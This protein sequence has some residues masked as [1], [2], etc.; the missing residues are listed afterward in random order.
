MKCRKGD[1]PIMPSGESETTFFE[2]LLKASRKLELEYE[3]TTAHV[4]ES[5]AR[6]MSAA[7]NFLE[8]YAVFNHIDQKTALDSYLR[9]NHRYVRDIQTF[10]ATGKYPLEIDSKQWDLGRADYD[11]SLILSILMAP[12]R[13]IIMEEITKTSVS[14]RPLVIGVGSGIELGF[15]NAINGGDAYDLYINGYARQAYPQW[16]FHEKLYRPSSRRYEA[17]YAIE[18]LE[19]LSEPYAFIVECRE[20]LAQGGRFVTTTASNVPQFDHRYNFISDEDFERQVN[21]MGFELE[22]KR[23]I[24]HEYGLMNIRASNVFSARNVFYVFRKN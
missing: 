2:E 11:L 23:V 14:G 21:A 9:T 4:S 12:H 22:S 1:S 16:S 17:I 15:I 7:A 20:S 13:R 5:G 18:L 19:H 8:G 10:I 3:L 24:P 6:V